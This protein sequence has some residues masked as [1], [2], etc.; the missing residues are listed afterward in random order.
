V[1]VFQVIANDG[2]GGT[3]SD[4]VAVT[5]QDTV[6]APE[7]SLARPSVA[8]LWPPNH[9]L[10][11]VTIL[12]V[13]DEGSNAVTI[14][15]TGVTQDE[16]INGLGDGDTAPDAV[17]QG[18]TVLLRAERA[19]GGNGRVYRVTFQASHTQG[20]TCTGTVLVTVPHSRG[21]TAQPAVDDGQ[22]YNSLGL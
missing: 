1:L 2:L 13:T 21:P 20:G 5:V 9:K 11:P 6:G 14:V 3:D 18:G 12:G 16:P 7:C 22:V 4:E 19:G 10:I 15:I 8:Q 17:I